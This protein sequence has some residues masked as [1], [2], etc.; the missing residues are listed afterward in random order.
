MHAD[1][2]NF[3]HIGN[4]ELRCAV[5]RVLVE[6]FVKHLSRAGSELVEEISA[7]RSQSLSTLAPCA[8]RR[9][10][11]QIT[12]QVEWVGVRLVSR[13]GQ[14]FEVDAAVFQPLDD[15]ATSLW[16]SPFASQLGGVAE[17]SA[18]LVGCVVGELYDAEL[19]AVRIE[20]VHEVGS[21]LH[22]A[23]IEVELASRFIRPIGRQWFGAF[24]FG[25][26]FRCDYCFFVDGFA[27][28]VNGLFGFDGWIAIEIGIGK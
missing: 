7:L 24:V 3:Q 20:F 5:L 15:V 28:L 13:F 6:K 9:V 12:N 25:F 17:E 10:E 4:H 11:R 19:V 8:Q 2:R 23:S 26:F 22:L 14:V 21:N 16:I 27:F 1:R 18:N